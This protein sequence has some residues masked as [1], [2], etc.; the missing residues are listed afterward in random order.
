MRITSDFIKDIAQ[1]LN[2]SV[3]FQDHFPSVSDSEKKCDQK[4]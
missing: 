3:S 1:N 2:E 4:M